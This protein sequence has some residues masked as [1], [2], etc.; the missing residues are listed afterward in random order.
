MHNPLSGSNQ[1]NQSHR[2]TFLAK[3]AT[4]ALLVLLTSCGG[5]GGAG[6]GTS[7]YNISGTVSGSFLPNVDIALTGPN[8]TA[9]IGPGTNIVNTTTDTD[10]NYRFTTLPNG[11]FTVTPTATGYTFNPA[12][13]SVTVNGADISV[14]GFTATGR[15]TKVCNS[16]QL[17]NVGNCPVD[18]ISGTDDNQWGC[19]K[20]N[21]TG[22]IWEVKTGGG[23]RGRANVYTNYDDTSQAQVLANNFPLT[24][25]NPTQPEI[26]AASNTIGYVNS[27]N[28]D[29][30]VTLC[31][32]TDWRM[33]TKDEL[34]SIATGTPAIIDKNWFPNTGSAGFY[35]WSSS[36]F[37]TSPEAAEAVFN[38]SSAGYIRGNNLLVRLVR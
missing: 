7:T 4:V 18:P 10:G 17:A 1:A 19:N 12:S 37:R 5:G 33:P 25:R 9:V 21:N 28:A 8:M 13:A 30:S 26:E 11:N 29:P 2:N 35:Y 16:G 3:A 22:L 23:L 20:D 32:N 14:P 38:G 6:T 34:L 24:Y 36:P 15:Y 27:V 31:G